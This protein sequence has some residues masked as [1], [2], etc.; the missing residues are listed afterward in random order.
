MLANVNVITKSGLKNLSDITNSD[1]IKCI[2]TNDTL[3]IEYASDTS[4]VI[5]NRI[6]LWLKLTFSNDEFLY[7]SY[8]QEFLL[9]RGIFKSALALIGER[10]M[11]IPSNDNSVEENFC[12]SLLVKRVELAK[13]QASWILN[14]PYSNFVIKIGDYEIVAHC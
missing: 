3:S 4:P 6:T 11:L 12:D 14:T 5:N 8:R 2:D 13:M 9:E 10:L 7:C 1:L